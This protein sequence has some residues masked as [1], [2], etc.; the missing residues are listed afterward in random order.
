[1]FYW[2]GSDNVSAGVQPWAGEDVSMKITFRGDGWTDEDKEEIIRAVQEFYEGLEVGA[3]NVFDSAEY[4]ETNVAHFNAGVGS[5]T[6]DSEKTGSSHSEVWSDEE[7][8]SPG[9][10]QRDCSRD[11]RPPVRDWAPY[12]V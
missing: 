10:R 12:V 2:Y 11:L 4:N 3:V 7:R 9:Y 1:M 8:E 6:V 5:I